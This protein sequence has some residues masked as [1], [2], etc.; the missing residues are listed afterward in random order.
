[1]LSKEHLLSIPELNGGKIERMTDVGFENYLSKINAFI[2]SFP[3][4]ADKLRDAADDGN[5][6]A[7]SKILSLD[8]CDTLDKLYADGLAQEC[9]K[10]INKL[11]GATTSTLDQDEV[12]AFVEQIIQ[13]VSALSID[14]QM[15]GHRRGPARRAPAPSAAP[16][17]AKERSG[18]APTIFTAGGSKG[19]SILAVDNAVMF[20]NTMKKLLKDYPYEVHCV[21]SGDEALHYLQQGNRPDMFLLDVEMPGMDGYELARRIKQSGQRSPIVFITANSAREYVDRAVAVGAVGLLM[22]PLR[23]NQLLA[24]LQEFI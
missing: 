13:S 4:Q 2:D 23:I 21:T 17:Q 7:L 9:R 12:E 1:M 24:K 22:K 18:S 10:Y 5:Y 19:A 6:P 20:L 14:I 11:A 16:V 3:G 8:V 15:S